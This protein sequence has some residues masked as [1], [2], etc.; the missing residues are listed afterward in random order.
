MARCMRPIISMSIRRFAAV[1]VPT[2]LLLPNAIR[3]QQPQPQAP[4]VHGVVV[5]A[6][7]NPIT[8]AEVS[9]LDSTNAVVATVNTDKHGAF[10]LNGV[11]PTVPHVFAARK[12]GFARGASKPITLRAI[13]TLD[14]HFTLD[15][16]SATL[17]TVVVTAT[18]NPAYYIDATEIAKHAVVDALDVVLMLRPRMLGDAYKE[19]RPDTS[20]LTFRAPR[21][22]LPLPQLA[23]PNDTIGQ[24]P[25]RLFINGIEHAIPRMKDILSQIQA[26]D[27]DQMRYVDCHDTTVPPQLRNVLFVVLKPGKDY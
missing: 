5:D 27:I 2:L 26:E 1:A 11:A 15:P 17:P 12:V 3:A 6:D 8:G 22:S 16:V 24:I 25:T 14:L 21:M 23:S 18:M 13:D 19:C 7:N 10:I 20:H 9:A 4:V